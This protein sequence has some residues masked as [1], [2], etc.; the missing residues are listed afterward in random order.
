[1]ARP[2][3]LT[4]D[5]DEPDEEMLAPAAEALRSGALVAFPTETVYGLGAN[6][7][8]ERAVE[9]VFAAKGRPPD[10]PLIVHVADAAGAWSVAAHV[11]PLARRLAERFWPGP[12][13]LVLDAAA[14][15][16]RATTAGLATVAIRVPD[17][18]VA[19]ALLRAAGVPVAAPSANRSGRPSPTTARH[20]VDDLGGAVD[21]VVD[22]GPCLVGVES[23]VVD[24][25]ARV[26][27]VLREGAIAREDLGEVVEPDA[28]DLP[29]APGTRHRHY[30]PSCRVVLAPAG[31]GPARALALAS[32]GQRVGLIAR[33]PAPAPVVT[34]ARF[35]AAADLAQILYAGL[36]SAERAAVDV[37]VV[38]AVPETGIGRAVMD[39]LRRAAQ[40][41]STD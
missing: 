17:H 4:V 36:R 25:R 11:T 8:D 34:V 5:P 37:V 13:T 32:S 40:A 21:V 38:E 35:A 12:L 29:L 18:P 3:L 28:A 9:R 7:L 31:D 1:V 19:L 33:D 26:V 27:T 20:V 30:A 16:P 23:T 22:G 2:T 39:R 41:S 24:A 6:A 15:V 10:N 14:A